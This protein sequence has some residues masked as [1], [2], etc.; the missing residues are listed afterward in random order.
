MKL[1]YLHLKD[2]L[3]YKIVLEATIDT[4]TMQDH[5]H[6]PHLESYVNHWNWLMANYARDTRLC[7]FCSYYKIENETR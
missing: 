3:K 6:S 5:C 4:T 1:D 7:H 2:F